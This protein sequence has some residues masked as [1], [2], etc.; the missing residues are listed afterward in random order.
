MD[1]LNIPPTPEERAAMNNTKPTY[2][3]KQKSWF[4]GFL[5]ALAAFLVGSI[6]TGA[7]S[8]FL[9]FI[10]V[11]SFA[12]LSDQPAVVEN[13]SVLKISLNGTI[14]ERAQE[15]PFA[16][17]LGNDMLQEQGLEN[18]LTAIREAK[19]NNKI[20][21]IYLEGGVLSTDYATLEEIR[22][23]LEDFKESGKF[24]IAY[25]EN[26]SQGAYYL[27]CLADKVMLNPSGNLDIHGIAAQPIF[28]KELL[29]KIGVKMQV[30]RVGTYKSAV[31]PFI[32]TEMS[33]ANREQVQS[34][35]NSTWN[36]LVDDIAHSRNM[37]AAQINE[38]ADNYYTL[39]GAE[40]AK[41]FGLVDTLAYSNGVRDALRAANGNAKVKF[42][43]PA[44]LAKFHNTL[45]QPQKQEVAVYY[46][47][48]EIVDE[49][50]TGLGGTEACI[51]G[52]KVV[53]DL[54]KL[55][56]DDN[57]KA[58]VLRINSP[59]GSANAS[60][61]MWNAI[62]LLKQKKPVIVSMGGLAASGGYYMSCNAN[63]IFAEPTT[64]TGSIGI[65][66]VVPNPSELLTEKLG[67]HFDVVK[68]NKSADFGA[69]GRGFNAAESAVLQTMIERGYALFLKRVADGRGMTTEEVNKIAQGRVWTGEQ[70]LEIG[71]VDSLGTLNNAIEFAANMA[72]LDNNYK[73]AS[74][75]ATDNI[76]EQLSNTLKEDYMERELK[77]MLGEHYQQLKF[78]KQ[79][80]SKPCVYARIPYDMN[81]Q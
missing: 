25:G 34:Y 15:N 18:I 48:G 31:E 3:V 38:Y 5:Q 24:V 52:S 4:H 42:I 43:T 79:A 29:E 61:Q 60:E 8:T 50:S 26:Y 49:I 56:N 68:T 51:V 57:V 77:S 22:T 16:S 39:E 69:L 75:P 32:A 35:I 76:F 11:G 27:A 33:P 66:G 63:K 30:F 37:T 23:A 44:E 6:I 70:G 20:N 28:Y 55:M 74:Y 78:I 80:S 21:G 81:L 19:T 41:D 65:F 47:Y 17:L 73:I 53:E 14:N 9:F 72:A 71:L 2:V 64:L 40:K 1:N 12:A 46:A 7:V 10:V 45:P 54:D 62:E 58:V 59:G 67:L 36:N 13:N